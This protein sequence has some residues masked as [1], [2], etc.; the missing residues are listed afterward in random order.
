MRAARGDPRLSTLKGATFILVPETGE[1]SAK[2]WLG[3]RLE[4]YDNELRGSAQL[5]G[6]GVAL[7]AGLG[8]LRFA[9][10]APGD[11]ARQRL[12]HPGGVGADRLRG[13][14]AG[15][16][17]RANKRPRIERRPKLLRRQVDGPSERLATGLGDEIRRDR[18]RL[19]AGPTNNRWTR[20][21]GPA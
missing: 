21:G 16:R 2:V 13:R 6:A 18:L 4:L 12:A 14:A 10:L 15:D 19:A 3:A 8:D 9:A 1:T 5:G 11:V 20:P 17:A 7:D